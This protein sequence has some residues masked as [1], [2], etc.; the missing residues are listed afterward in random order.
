MLK[1]EIRIDG[2]TPELYVDNRRQSRLI[3]RNTLPDDLAIN[4]TVILEK[5]DVKILMVQSPEFIPLCWDGDAG[6]DYTVYDNHVRKFVDQ[7]PDVYLILFV[8]S[9]MAAPYKWLQKNE[10][11]LVLFDN[12]VR[13]CVPSLGSSKWKKD[14]NQA[15]ARFVEH[16]E[17]GPYSDH[18]L[19][20]N[21]THFGNEWAIPNNWS[22]NG[23]KCYPDFSKAFQKH[24]KQWLRVKYH[25]DV[26]ALREAWKDSSVSFESAAIPTGEQRQ[27]HTSGRTISASG[28]Y[29]CKVAD[30]YRCLL[31]ANTER[32]LG[33]AKTIKDACDRKKLVSIMHGYS[34]FSP[35]GNG[36]YSNGDVPRLHGS[37]D[38][39]LFHAPYSYF[40]RNFGKGCHYSMIAAD[41]VAAHGKLMISQSD[42]NTHLCAPEI[43]TWVDPLNDDRNAHTEWE[44]LQIMKRDAAY[45]MQHQCGLYWLDGGPGKMFTWGATGHGAPRYHKFWFDSPSMK[46][47]IADLQKL[48]D[49]NRERG[50][51]RTAQIC[52]LK[53]WKSGFFQKCDNTFIN[54]FLIGFRNWILPRLGAQFDDYV[55]EDWDKVPKGYKLYIF[56]D[57]FDVTPELRRSIR[58]RLAGEGATALWLYAPGFIDGDR[59]NLDAMTDLTGIKFTAVPE[60]DWVQVQLDHTIDNPLLAGVTEPEFG[61]DVDYREF[62]KD[63]NWFQFPKDREENYRMSPLFCTEDATVLGRYRGNGRAGLSVKT[64]EDGFTSV[65]CGAPCLPPSILKNLCSQAGIHLYTW[66]EHLVYV[67]GCFLGITFTSAGT[68][69]IDLPA[70]SDVTNCFSRK[71]EASGVTSFEVKAE[72][73]ETRLFWID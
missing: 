46:Q 2:N 16:F 28:P 21:P 73:G 37:P 12:G 20:Y 17:N 8:G 44:T 62:A 68:H 56:M 30:Y 49:E 7:N 66:D 9:W 71:A 43:N 5:A 26:N 45:T 72:Y 13:W 53:S 54:L 50:G 40:N 19:G 42:S 27:K 67:N 10:D 58:E 24:F 18:I 33:Y 48:Q 51:K 64:T 14:A 39:D 36:A 57:A 31:D 60:K 70:T 59:E 34:H 4:K 11:D 65:F 29:G 32:A 35:W 15:M 52:T 61:S 41:N 6:Y 38:I 47:M 63:V 23:Q 25:D 1:T 69:R 3:G 22:Y 55:L